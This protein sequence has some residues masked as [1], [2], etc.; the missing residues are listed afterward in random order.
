MTPSPMEDTRYM[1][2]EVC[3][4]PHACHNPMHLPSP[5]Q[6]KKEEA[7]LAWFFSGRASS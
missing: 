4:A 1:L 2:N 7:N 5:L 6:K 3:C